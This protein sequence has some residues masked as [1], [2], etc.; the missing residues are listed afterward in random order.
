[1]SLQN[2]LKFTTE[3]ASAI[4]QKDEQLK[5]LQ[6]AKRIERQK[7]PRLHQLILDVIETNGIALESDNCCKESVL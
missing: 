3:S 7:N 2:L 4:A 6:H 5:S 1:M